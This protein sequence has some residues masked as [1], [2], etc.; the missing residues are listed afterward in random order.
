[1]TNLRNGHRNQQLKREHKARCRAV[2]AP[3]HLCRQPIDYAAPA[4]TSRA[5]ESDHIISVK[6]R[7]DLAYVISN[8]APSCHA[9]NRAKGSR[10]T[11]SSGDWVAADW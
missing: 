9:C 11:P 10:P 1:M 7:P 4:N 2:N 3:C 5:F 8:L 6:A